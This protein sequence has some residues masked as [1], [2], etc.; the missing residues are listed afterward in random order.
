MRVEYITAQEL[1]EMFFDVE[2]PFCKKHTLIEK[3]RSFTKRSV[4]VEYRINFG[5]KH[6][7]VFDPLTRVVL[8]AEGDEN[9]RM[10]MEKP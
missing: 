4:G 10:A 8:F 3:I 7:F 5:C 2:C 9:G 1:N 6:C